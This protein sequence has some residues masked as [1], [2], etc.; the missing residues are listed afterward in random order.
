MEGGFSQADEQRAFQVL[1]EDWE[2]WIRWE[3]AFQRRDASI[4]SHPALPQ[5]RARYEALK[6]AIGDK[7]RADRSRARF[8][9]A[10]FKNL[11]DGRMLVE[12]RAADA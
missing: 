4:R 9:N 3:A 2:I 12:W 8:M 6:I 11:P 1:L 7:L 10:T 5:D